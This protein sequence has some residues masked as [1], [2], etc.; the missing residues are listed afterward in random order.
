[1]V[2]FVQCVTCRGAWAR[3]QGEGLSSV[4]AQL[5]PARAGLAGPSGTGKSC[6]LRYKQDKIPYNYNILF[7]KGFSMFFMVV[8]LAPLPLQWLTGIKPYLGNCLGERTLSF[9]SPGQGD[10]PRFIPSFQLTRGNDILLAD[11]RKRQ[12]SHGKQ[13]CLCSMGGTQRPRGEVRAG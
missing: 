2:D 11:G 7:S 3:V 9:R 1:M 5:K 13:C 10:A 12:R 8:T 6:V 4:Q